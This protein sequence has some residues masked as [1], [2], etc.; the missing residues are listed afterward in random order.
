MINKPKLSQLIPIILVIVIF[1]GGGYFGYSFWE[2]AIA[3]IIIISFII[4]YIKKL[5]K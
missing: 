4:F 3:V 1:Q 5:K 2:C